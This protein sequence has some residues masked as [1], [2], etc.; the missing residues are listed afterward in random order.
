MHPIFFDSREEFREWVA[1]HHDTAEELWVGYYKVDAERSGISYDASVEEALCY[2]WIDGL[3]NGIDSTRYKRRFTPRKPDSK[4][5]KK[6]T[7]RVQKMLD[8]GKMT[9]AGMELVEAAKESGEWANAYCLS[10]DHEIPDALAT[11]LR[12]NEAA[13]KN[14]RALSNTD[15][16]AFISLVEAAKTEATKRKRIDRAVQ[17]AERNLRAYDGDNKR[18]L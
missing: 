12:A 8:A 16:Y 17:L 3:I 4:W 1:E 2:G 15:Q 6:N 7:E 18:R 9:P 10:D 5:S 11:A 13:W 14:F